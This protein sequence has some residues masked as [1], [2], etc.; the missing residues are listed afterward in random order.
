MA[1]DTTKNQPNFKRNNLP[2]ADWGKSRV[3]FFEGSSTV[4]RGRLIK[5]RNIKANVDFVLPANVRVH[6]DIV[7]F[8]NNAANAQAAITIGTAAAGTQVSAGASVAA[9][10]T[11]IQAAT[12]LEPTRADRRLYVASAAWQDGVHVVIRVTEY[13]PVADTSALS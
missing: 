2:T 7:V 13:P 9:L 6:G 12:D 1:Y 4:P 10:T 3:A 11:D 5:L 8:N